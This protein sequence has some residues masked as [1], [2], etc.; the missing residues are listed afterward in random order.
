MK[1]H[2]KRY[3]A[4]LDNGYMLVGDYKYHHIIFIGNT[5]IGEIIFRKYKNYFIIGYLVIYPEY[6]RKSYGYQVVEYILSHYRIDCIVGEA[7]NSAAGFWNKCIIRFSGQRKNLSLSEN[8]SSSFVIPKQKINKEDIY[9][10]LEISC[11][12]TD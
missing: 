6:R 3:S 10:L 5:P 1:I 11:K 8:C 7:L 2:F 12:I 9:E 4:K